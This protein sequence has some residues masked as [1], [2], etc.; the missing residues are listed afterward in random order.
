MSWL[1]IAL[2][3]CAVAVVVGAEWPRLE[4]RFG[5]EARKKRE[6]ARRKANFRLVKSDTDDFAASVERDLAQLPTIEETDRR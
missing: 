6:R 3:L 4:K 1:Y 5:L 2:L